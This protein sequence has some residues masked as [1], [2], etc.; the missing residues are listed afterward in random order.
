[1]GVERVFLGSMQRRRPGAT[2]TT[3]R[4]GRTASGP[5]STGRDRDRG[6][7]G[8]R[9]GGAR[10]SGALQGSP[11]PSP[12]R[13]QLA[14]LQCAP[15]RA[16]SNLLQQL[17]STKST[18]PATHP[19]T[20]VC[21]ANATQP[22]MQSTPPTPRRC[23]ARS[24]DET[25]QVR[26]DGWLLAMHARGYQVRRQ[27]LLLATRATR[28]RRALLT[29]TIEQPLHA[30]S[31]TLCDAP[32]QVGTY[33]D[34]TSIAPRHHLDT[35]LPPPPTSYLA[36]THYTV[37]ITTRP[38]GRLVGDRVRHV[39]STLAGAHGLR[40]TAHAPRPRLDRRSPRH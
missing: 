22:A 26:V 34:C 19:S 1:V 27:A 18:E 11:A 35:H 3:R 28:A 31:C 12:A 6:G 15:T 10:R 20:P 33:L 25:L 38:A 39:P 21:C 14:S 32:R 13:S 4:S 37:V 7:M 8:S 24:Q 23:Q 9:A 16:S 5:A 36:P 30:R 40:P 29:T 2:R 17:P